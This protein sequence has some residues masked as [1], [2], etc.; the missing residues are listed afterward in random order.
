MTGLTGLYAAFSSRT[1]SPVTTSVSCI[2]V[3]G[4]GWQIGWYANQMATIAPK[5][6]AGV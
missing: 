6:L 5:I 4:V 1:D 2:A 3:K